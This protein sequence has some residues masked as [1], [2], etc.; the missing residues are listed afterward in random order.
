MRSQVLIL[1]TVLLIVTSTANLASGR[2][3]TSGSSTILADPPQNDAGSGDDAPPYIQQAVPIELGVNYSGQVGYGIIGFNNDSDYGDTYTFNITSAGY[4]YITVSTS[5]LH[6]DG[7]IGV[8]IYREE[9]YVVVGLG[10]FWISPRDGEVSL[11]AQVG[12]ATKMYFSI[13]PRSE[14]ATYSWRLGFSATSGF[15]PQND[16]GSGV[17]AAYDTAIQLSLNESYTGS[18]GGGILNVQEYEDNVDN[19]LFLA[20]DSGFLHLNVTGSADFPVDGQ[21]ELLSVGITSQ[22]GSQ[23]ERG[24]I[25]PEEPVHTLTL[26]AL[27]G[28]EYTIEFYTSAAWNVSYSFMLYQ[29]TEEIPPQN[30]AGSG[31]DAGST[32]EGAVVFAVNSTIEGTLGSSLLDSSTFNDD[33][34]DTY[35][36]EIPY[37]GELTMGLK[38]LD[39]NNEYG[40][41]DCTVYLSSGGEFTTLMNL[42][43]SIGRSADF[44]SIQVTEGSSLVVMVQGA[45]VDNTTTYTV[46]NTL[47]AQNPTSLTDIS[48]SDLSGNGGPGNVGIPFDLNGMIMAVAIV[49]IRRKW[50]YAKRQRRADT[51]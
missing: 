35:A 22:S 14:N 51:K 19:Y 47:V 46:K 20:N 49:A 12:S 37:D 4:L 40:W 11:A 25:S 41:I 32:V 28:M 42:A 21:S 10:S 2:I 17:D 44:R 13:N 43:T 29:G 38:I 16:A 9:E 8:S 48:G 36:L 27:A 23:Y 26:Y 45:D 5:D 6:Y 1:T 15:P 18:M 39:S 34:A 30:D 24:S 33:T 7:G 50:V 3:G 31:R